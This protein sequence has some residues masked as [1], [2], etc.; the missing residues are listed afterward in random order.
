[1]T[2]KFIVS[3]LIVSMLLAF[4]P[5]NF[6][7][8]AEE[9]TV[10]MEI[11][12]GPVQYK[13][14]VY[15]EWIEAS[16]TLEIYPGYYINAGPGGSV[17]FH[18]PDGSKIRLYE[19]SMLRLNELRTIGEK[20]NYTVRFLGKILAKPVESPEKTSYFLNNAPTADI[21]SN[22]KEFT[23]EVEGNLFVQVNVLKGSASANDAFNTDGT[24]KEIFP[25]ENMFTL[26]T[27][28][29][30]ILKVKAYPHTI[31]YQK[32][33]AYRKTGNPADLGSMEDLKK[34]DE[35][36]VFGELIDEATQINLSGK[37]LIA[38][39]ITKRSLLP[40]A[41]WN[42]IGPGHGAVITAGA[43]GAIG[44]VIIGVGVGGGGMEPPPTE[45]PLSPI[46][47]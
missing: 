2:K 5:V 30:E 12:T 35:V 17:L 15:G 20:R 47:P 31:Y 37:S 14:E 21:S 26:E 10:K 33:A 7:A 40:V 8:L 13:T 34:G 39:L 44:A 27:K 43:L 23:A 18:F 4:T 11:L 42:I 28:D 41:L 24:V 3:F 36:V 9:E 46:Q 25:E 45:P 16:E 19:N 22:G 38:S 29:K 32:Y 1:M 6:P